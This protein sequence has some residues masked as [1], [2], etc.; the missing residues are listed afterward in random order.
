MSLQSRVLERVLK[1][2]PPITRKIE[3]TKGL[4][5]PAY[6]GTVLLADLYAPRDIPDAPTLLIR[7]PYGRNGLVSRMFHRQ[8]A[9]RGYQVLVAATRGTNGSGGV[10]D[11]L[12]GEAEDGLATL[13]WIEKQPWHNGQIVTIGPSYLGYTQLAMAPDAGDR[14]TA[15]LPM[16]GSTQF[17]DLWTSAGAVPLEFTLSWTSRTVTGRRRGPL[18]ADLSEFTGYRRANRTMTHLPLGTADAAVTGEQVGFY[19]HFVE[20]GED[21]WWVGRGSRDRAGEITTPTLLFGGWH[22]FA[23]LPMVDD[24]AAMRA[25]GRNPYLTIGPWF[26]AD[27]GQAVEAVAEALPWF[28]AHLTGDLS[29]FREDPIR[30]FVQGIDEWR[31]YPTFPPPGVAPRTWS[32]AAGGVLA[33]S[34]ADEGVVLDKFTFDPARPTPDYGGALLSPKAAGRKEQAGREARPDVVTW[35][36][37]ELSEPVEV[38][39][40]VTAEIRL[41][42]SSEYADTFVRLC[43]VSPDGV[44][45]NVTDALL[46]L[47]PENAPVDEDGVRTAALRLAPTAYQFKRG[48]RLRVQVSGGSFPRYDRNAGTGESPMTATRLVSVDHEVLSG[49]AI[50]LSV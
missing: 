33:E 26:H 34:A 35:S 29:G 32:L 39:G 10:L 48:H 20:A 1:L 3:V 31:S 8:F 36:S 5:I 15:M 46:R 49:S 42:T 18:A 24:Y 37:A 28:G 30:L 19:R 41:R 7:T 47:T 45:V 43:D 17:R 27:L 9:E 21:E 22:D 23:L 44:S 13:D 11:P 38:I 4:E 12:K 40:D 25:A 6:D 16:I 50:T 14:I 2:P